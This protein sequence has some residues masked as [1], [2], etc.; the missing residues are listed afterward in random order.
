MQDQ[1]NPSPTSRD[2][3]DSNLAQE[4]LKKQ[5]RREYRAKR[6]ALSAKQHEAAARSLA[7]IARQYRQIFGCSRV[8]SY[9][10]I[11]GEINPYYLNNMLGA[12]LFLPKIS[13]YRNGRM[14]FLANNLQQRTNSLG[15]REPSNGARQLP[16]RHF[17]AILVPLL[18]FDRQGRRLG[19]GGGFYDRA[20]AFKL[21]SL[22]Q[23]RPLLIGLAH[24]FQESEQLS[25]APWDVPL[26][27]I[28]T[29]SEL[30]IC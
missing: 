14:K 15:I 4:K 23:K 19:M 22:K 10:P 13:H 2:S 20:F 18:A 16:A 8:L 21:D 12:D 5:L 26:D 7:R 17:D 6:K 24:H 9:A 29:D 28:I 11:L 1:N 3:I 30:I 25:S 27:V